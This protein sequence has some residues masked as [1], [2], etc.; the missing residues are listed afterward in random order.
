MINYTSRLFVF[1]YLICLTSLCVNAQLP[2]KGDW[3]T[4]VGVKDPKRVAELM[5]DVFNK[6]PYSDPDVELDSLGYVNFYRSF[7]QLIDIAPYADYAFYNGAF[8][9]RQRYPGTPKFVKDDISIYDRLLKNISDD[10]AVKMV[11]MDD[12]LTIGRNFVDNLDSVNIVR[13]NGA[14][15]LKSADDTLSLPVAMTQYAHL[16]YKYAGNPEYYPAHLY[17]KVQA[18]ENYRN[19]FQLLVKNNIEPGDELQAVFL[20]E[21]YRTCEQLFKTSEE[22]YFEQFLHDYLEI[23][24]SCDNLLIPFYDVPDSIKNNE[25]NELYRNYQGYNYW[26]NHDTEG[27]KALFANSGALSI[28]R[29]NNYYLAKLPEHKSDHEYMER[30]LYVMSELKASRTQAYYDYSV[31][32]YAIKPTYLN[33]LG[34]AFLS[35]NKNSLT[36]MDNFCSQAVDLAPDSLHKGLVY[37]YTAIEIEPR[38]IKMK[39][40]NKQIVPVDSIEYGKWDFEMTIARNYI[41]KMMDFSSSFLNSNKIEHREYPKRISYRYYDIQRFTGRSVFDRKYIDDAQKYLKYYSIEK[42]D[43]Y[44]KDLAYVERGKRVSTAEKVLSKEQHD[45]LRN[46]YSRVEGIIK[47]CVFFG[48]SPTEEEKKLLKMY[49]DYYR[50]YS[51]GYTGLTSKEKANFADYQ[52]FKKQ[53]K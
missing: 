42:K 15:N 26:T 12:I 28:E 49:E 29:I 41:D 33:C 48:G 5:Q 37:Y 10:P 23:V 22:F 50:R 11:L 38:S 18:R 7:S 25:N 6:P 44:E 13:N 35:W 47:V 43:E 45:W 30:A 3:R 2:E 19:A 53:I 34:C 32:S 36:E 8:S 24:Q 39:R 20:N 21:Y 14:T 46:T 27:I 51:S 9:E 4:R 17:D 40:V 31:A 16:Y 52:R 1:L